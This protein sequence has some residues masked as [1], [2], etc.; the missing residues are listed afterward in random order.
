MSASPTRSTAVCVLGMSR[1]GTSLTARVLELAGVYLGSEDDLLGGELSQIPAKDRGRA[2]EANPGG[3]W[4]HYRL[5]RLN[6][7][8]LRR[9][10]GS[11]REPPELPPGW[12]TSVDLDREREEALEL[13]EETFAGHD[14]WGWKDPRSSLTLPFWQQLLPDLRHVICLRNPLDV[15]LSLQKRDGM[16]VE[17]GLELWRAYASASLVNTADRP[18]EL[19]PYEAYF[20]D[21]EAVSTRLARFVGREGAFATGGAVGELH[22]AVDR[23]LWRQRT[24]AKA[25][26]DDDRVPA[27]VADLYRFAVRLSG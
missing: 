26:A 12:E 23:R 8:I 27:E 2:G 3:F 1:S 6:E 14:L 17:Q 20:D 7:R 15:A 22:E 16:A 4:E 18:R 24:A 13:I 25:V 5:M 21:A 10:G 9:L 11:W 19:V